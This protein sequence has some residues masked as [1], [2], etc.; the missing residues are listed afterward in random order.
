MLRP[1]RSDVRRFRYAL[2]ASVAAH[3]LFIGFLLVRLPMSKPPEPPEP[4]PIEMA[5]EDSGPPATPH[6]ADT[7]APKP[8]PAPAPTPTDAPPA[9]TPPT[10]EPVEEPQPPPPPPQAVPPPA[11]SKT[12]PLPDVKTP[13]KMVDDS[14]EP[15]K[16]APPKPSPPSTSKQV[17]P[18]SPQTQPVDKLPETPSFSHITQPNP[19]KKTQT[20]SHSLLATLD[21]FRADQKQTHPPKARANPKQGGAPNGGG[22]PNGDITS[23]LSDAQQKAIGSGVRPCYTEDT[24]ARNYASFSAYLIVTVDQNGEARIVRFTPATQAKMNADPSYRALAE[25]AREAVLSPRCA[26]L[27]VPSGFLGKSHDLIFVFRP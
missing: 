9:P 2:G 1:R 6:K 18:P 27:P 17:A 11:E 22:S 10:P 14:A 4:P 13:E 7:P 24:A 15:I 20:D 16:A 23:A 5:F 19:A 26:K 8:A 21:A 12:P 25:R 3:A